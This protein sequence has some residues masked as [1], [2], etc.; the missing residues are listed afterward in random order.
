MFYMLLVLNLIV[1]S[2][3]N[4]YNVVLTDDQCA[5]LWL[6]VCLGQLRYL[7]DNQLNNND[8]VVQRTAIN[9][10]FKTHVY[11]VKTT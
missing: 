5:K 10:V 4:K 3:D 7:P 6:S 11:S 9:L 2:G 1:K 8:A